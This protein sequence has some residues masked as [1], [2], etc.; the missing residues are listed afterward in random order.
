MRRRVSVLLLAS[1]GVLGALAPSASGSANPSHAS[2]VALLTSNAPPGA[3]GQLVSSLAQASRPWG[4]S[5]R[6]AAKA[7]LTRPLGCPPP[8]GPPPD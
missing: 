8:P 2:C 6:V 3:V 7:K 4:Q 1:L 5:V